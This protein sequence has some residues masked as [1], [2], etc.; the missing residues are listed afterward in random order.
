MFIE[1][2]QVCFRISVFRTGIQIRSS[3]TLLLSVVNESE[4]KGFLKNACFSSGLGQWIISTIS[5][6]RGVRRLIYGN[7]CS[8]NDSYHL[9]QLVFYD[10]RETGRTQYSEFTRQIGEAQAGTGQKGVSESSWMNSKQIHLILYMIKFNSTNTF[11]K[12][13]SF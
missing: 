8:M 13:S 9:D 6:R 1:I 4:K 2:I 12:N 11:C 10:Y 5:G 3:S 7:K